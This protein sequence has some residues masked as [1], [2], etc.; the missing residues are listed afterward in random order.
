MDLQIFI[1]LGIQGFKC[2]QIFIQSCTFLG[3]QQILLGHVEEE[4]ADVLAGDAVPGRCRTWNSTEAR[5]I[6]NWTRTDDEERNVA[7]R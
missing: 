6:A 2:Q 7:H 5:S 3:Q 1:L 4:H